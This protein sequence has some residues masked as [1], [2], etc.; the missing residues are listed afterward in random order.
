MYKKLL[1]IIFV[2]LV[3]SNNAGIFSLNKPVA[4]QTIRTTCFKIKPQDNK[5]AF[6][7]PYPK[8]Y[9][10]LSNII[11]IN[12]Q[13]FIKIR[14]QKFPLYYFDSWVSV[15]AVKLIYILPK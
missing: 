2:I 12:G 11:I 9:K 6:S 8:I 13:K 5:C 14:Y 10:T 4:I 7:L 15:Y 3:V 1:Q